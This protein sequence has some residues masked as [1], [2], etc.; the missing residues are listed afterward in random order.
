MSVG[1][2][3]PAC[4]V[5]GSGTSRQGTGVG[6]RT[7]RAVG[8]RVGRD[9]RRMEMVAEDSSAIEAVAGCSPR[10]GQKGGAAAADEEPGAAICRLRNAWRRRLRIEVAAEPGVPVRRSE[11]RLD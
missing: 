3:G 5:A 8:R 9:A 2:K 7:S 11:G 4:C 1:D 6:L 10:G